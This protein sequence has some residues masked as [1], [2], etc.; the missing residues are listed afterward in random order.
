MKEL[1]RRITCF[2]TDAVER[3]TVEPVAAEAL[4]RGYA[5]LFS[6]NVHEEAEIGLYCQ[7][8]SSPENSRLSVVMLHDVAQ[9]HNRWPGFWRNEPWSKFDVGILPGASWSKRWRECSWD[10]GANARLGVYECG[11]PKADH[12][13]ADREG[14]ERSVRELRESLDLEYETSVLYAPSWEYDGRQDEFVRTLCDL[15][16]NLLLKQSPWYDAHPEVPC[17]IDSM[18]GLHRGS[19]RNVRVLDPMTDI[20]ACIALASVIVSEESATL[21]EGVLLEVPGIAVMDWLVPDESPAREP[22]VPFEFVTKT[23]R[24]SLV[25]AVEDVLSDAGALRHEL[26]SLRAELFSNLGTAA[27]SIMDRIDDAVDGSGRVQDPL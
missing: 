24:A 21:V 15:P 6:E 2:H 17:S 12:M 9:G 18:N 26:R 7:H 23:R 27:A 4:R 5:V 11:W 13:F 25:Q 3:Q 19:R 10:P 1:T 14:F 16:I 20:M 8:Q 22:S